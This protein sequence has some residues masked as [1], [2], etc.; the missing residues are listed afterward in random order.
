MIII[1][2]MIYILMKNRENFKNNLYVFV[3]LFADVSIYLVWVTFREN[4]R[5]HIRVSLV[6]CY[7][8]TPKTRSLLKIDLETGPK[9]CYRSL[10]SINYEKMRGICFDWIKFCF[11]WNFKLTYALNNNLKKIN[12]TVC[13]I[14]VSYTL[15]RVLIIKKKKK[16]RPESAYFR[17]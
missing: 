16:N 12:W 2:A 9:R 11:Y 6:L 17:E 1:Q 8:K 10:R 5:V 15:N 4:F 14:F 3:F 13:I 7:G